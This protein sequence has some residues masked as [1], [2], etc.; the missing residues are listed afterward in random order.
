[1]WA[2]PFNSV[3]VS[4]IIYDNLCHGKAAQLKVMQLLAVPVCI[5]IMD[6]QR[7]K[8]RKCLNMM[9]IRQDLKL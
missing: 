9:I 6:V 8:N 1:M 4:T 2:S 7:T 5:L 3:L